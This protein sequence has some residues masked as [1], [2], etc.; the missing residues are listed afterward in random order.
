MAKIRDDI[1][2]L[3]GCEMMQL[4]TFLCQKTLFSATN[5][6]ITLNFINEEKG[7][8]REALDSLE[9]S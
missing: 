9:K 2:D 6:S 5:D 1:T 3:E 8:K 4:N 7:E